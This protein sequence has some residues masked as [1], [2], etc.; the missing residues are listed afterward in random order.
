MTTKAPHRYEEERKREG[1]WGEGNYKRELGNRIRKDKENEAEAKSEGSGV[2]QRQEEK[3]ERGNIEGLL[4]KIQ[5]CHQ[6]SGAN[7]LLNNDIC[8]HYLGL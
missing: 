2:K 7:L 1:T 6:N 5:R 8:P 4:A 3:A